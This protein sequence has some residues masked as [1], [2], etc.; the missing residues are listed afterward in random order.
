MSEC[1]KR[2]MSQLILIVHIFSYKTA[3]FGEC[4]LIIHLFI[5]DFYRLYHTR[6]TAN[7]QALILLVQKITLFRFKKVK[8]NKNDS[9]SFL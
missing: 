7:F 1:S 5:D 4:R 6:K 8:M 9:V 2:P 3:K